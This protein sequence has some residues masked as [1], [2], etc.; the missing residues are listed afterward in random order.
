M[1]RNFKELYA[2]MPEQARAE[3]EA[4]VQQSLQTLALDELRAA[5]DI[6]QVELARKLHTNQGAISKLEKRTDMYLSTLT[7]V[8]HAMGGQLELRAVFP[9]GRVHVLNLKRL[10]AKTR[11]ARG[12]SAASRQGALAG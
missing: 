9:S 2:R 7:D 1:A 10:K 5:M 11:R 3:V 8:I 6:T 12:A 4:R